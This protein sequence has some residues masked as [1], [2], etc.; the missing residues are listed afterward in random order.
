MTGDTHGIFLGHAMPWLM[1]LVIF[2]WTPPHFWALALVSCQDYA[3]AKIPMLPLT[4]G[5]TNTRWQMLAYTLVLWGVSVLPY[6]LGYA[7]LTYGIAAMVLGGLFTL[8]AVQV[9]RLKN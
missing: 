9:L 3:K 7:S 8:S 5:E 4:H 1:F 2:L 6:I